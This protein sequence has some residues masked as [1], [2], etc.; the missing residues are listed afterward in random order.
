MEFIQNN[1]VELLLALITLGSSWTALT[2]TKKDDEILDI[3]KRV[4]NAIV[5]GKNTCAKDCKEECK[6][7]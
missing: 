2:A 5:L 7:K 6:S 4:F 1:W 3:I